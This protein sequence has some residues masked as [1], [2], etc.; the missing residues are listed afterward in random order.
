MLNMARRE[1]LPAASRF[2][3]DL[4]EQ[5]NAKQTFSREIDCSYELSS[6]TEISSLIASMRENT[7]LLGRSIKDSREIEGSYEKARFFRDVVFT[8]MA[9]LRAC[10]DKLERLVSHD[11]WPF[12]VYGEILFSVK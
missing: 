10:A 2:S 4:A 3:G 5:A 6:V 12:P 1:I 8:R 9:T 11:Y 7:D